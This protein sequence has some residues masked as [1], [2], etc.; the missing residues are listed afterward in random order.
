MKIF[1]S[2]PYNISK[3]K[4]LNNQDRVVS[5][6]CEDYCGSYPTII[7][8]LSNLND[9]EKIKDADFVIFINNWKPKFNLDTIMIKHYET[10]KQ[11]NKRI[12]Y[13]T[14]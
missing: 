3:K 12:I 6:L 13:Y 4:V 14:I 11:F 9:I 1:I 7:N 5:Y 10:A 2:Q 8:N